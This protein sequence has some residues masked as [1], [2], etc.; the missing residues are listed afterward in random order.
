[1]D[2]AHH[3]TRAYIQAVFGAVNRPT[4]QVVAS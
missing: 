4:A 1:M 2:R 3:L